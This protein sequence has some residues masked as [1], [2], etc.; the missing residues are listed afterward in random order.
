LECSDGLD[1]ADD[2]DETDGIYLE[3]ECSDDSDR[4]DVADE[5]DGFDRQTYRYFQRDTPF[6]CMFPMVYYFVFQLNY[7]RI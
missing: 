6:Q 3:L 5:T 2:A 4:A 1:G 7:H